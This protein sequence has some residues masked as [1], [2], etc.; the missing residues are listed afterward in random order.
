ML[1]P[2]GWFS[3][4]KRDR[5]LCVEIS[6]VVG[7]YVGVMTIPVLNAHGW[8][9]GWTPAA[10]F[11]VPVAPM[12]AILAFSAAARVRRLSIVVIALVGVQVC[13]D[14]V[15]WQHPGLLWNDGIG[16]SA[17]L[18]Y[19]DGGTGWLS[20]LVPSLLEPVGGRTIAMIAAA[21]IGCLLFT[22]W[23]TRGSDDQLASNG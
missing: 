1:A 4:W 10:R 7:A 14:A 19:L 18:K 22:A 2:A 8:R 9:G 16:T 11:L 3:L 12:L 5:E 13:L 23:L 20:S 21:S 6:L 15:V 17:L